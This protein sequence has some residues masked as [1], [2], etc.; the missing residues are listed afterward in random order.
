MSLRALRPARGPFDLVLLDPPYA[1]GAKPVDELL[2]NLA[3]QGLLTPG[4]YALFEHAAA[5]AGAHPAGFVTVREKRYGITSVDLLRWV[6]EGEDD[7]IATDA[8]DSDGTTFQ[9]DAHE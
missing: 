6:G 2:Q 8:D 3:Q 5:D 4:A 7:D 1:F 9:E